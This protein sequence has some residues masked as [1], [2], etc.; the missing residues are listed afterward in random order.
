[1][2][3]GPIGKSHENVERCLVVRVKISIAEARKN[4]VH[5]VPRHTNKMRCIQDL[6]Q[7]S[8]AVWKRADQTRL[9]SNLAIAEFGDCV[10]N[11]LFE[12]LITSG[13]EHHRA[14]REVVTER[15]SL[16]SNFY[17]GLN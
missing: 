11:S 2:R 14:S 3:D 9:T 16:A 17:P 8:F 7:W 13:R 5:C 1:M 12:P 15:V 10:I 4:L 6:I